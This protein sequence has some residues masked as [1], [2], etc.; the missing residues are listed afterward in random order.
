MG[1]S[2]QKDAKEREDRFS[3]ILKGDGRRDSGRGRSKKNGS[4]GEIKCGRWKIN[5]YYAR[6]RDDRL[7]GY[8]FYLREHSGRSARRDGVS[9]WCQLWTARPPHRQQQ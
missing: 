9:S 3:R 7:K 1:P 8:V 6:R 4:F 5:V 2:L